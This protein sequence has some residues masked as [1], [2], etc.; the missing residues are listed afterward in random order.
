LKPTVQTPGLRARPA[1]HA[2]AMA[3]AVAGIGIAVV[4]ALFSLG[5]TVHA[6]ELRAWALVVFA[7]GLFATHVLPEHVTA[8]LVMLLAVVGGVAPTPVV[9]SGF[10][11]GALWL[12]FAGIIIAQAVEEAGL[13]AFLAHRFLGLWTL[14]YPRAI[15][16]LVTVASLL[17]F[18]IPATIPRIILLMPLALGMAEAMGLRAGGRGYAGLAMAVGLGT[19]FPDFAIITANL[20]AVVHVGAIEAIHGIRIS[21]GEFLFYNLPVSGL[22]RGAIIVI[23]LIGLFREPALAITE[24]QSEP[25]TGTQKRLLA[26][27]LGTLVL[28]CTDVVHGVQPA[29]VAMAAA[30]VIL[31]PATKLISPSAFK[32]RMS[33][34]PVLYI[35][36]I[37]SIG[38]IM[39]HNGLDARVGDIVLGFL[40]NGTGDGIGSFYLVGLISLVACL[41][42]TAPAA[43]ALLVP[44][45]ADISGA[46]G[47]PLD[48]VLMIQLLGFSTMLLPYQAPPLIV[49]LG[50][51][52]VRVVDVAKVCTLLGVATVAVG[53]P[54]AFFWWRYIGLL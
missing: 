36:G 37:L 30:I 21:Y 14:T 28:W 10:E 3:V 42:S 19:F 11:V 26:V 27:L 6:A 17:G 49:M 43:P 40:R 24:P 34:A 7:I 15:L 35:A 16:L 32:D 9:F 48:G 20:P 52:Q 44:I 50:L 13:G 18:V 25:M 1:G 4:L 29:W 12:L 31:W 41:V 22:F 39:V 47:L 8:L 45:A 54:L 46:T 5:A 23:L 51:C 2:A 38:A 53:F 33:F